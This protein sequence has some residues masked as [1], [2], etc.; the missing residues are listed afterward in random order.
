MK[1]YKPLKLTYVRVCVFVYFEEDV[2]DVEKATTSKQ[3]VYG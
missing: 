1:K 3:S 2:P